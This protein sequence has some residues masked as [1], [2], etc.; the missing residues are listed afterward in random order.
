MIHSQLIV[1][2]AIAKSIVIAI[3]FYGV[4]GIAIAIAKMGPQPI[5]E[6]N[7]N[8]NRVINFRCEWT[9]TEVNKSHRLY[10]YSAFISREAGD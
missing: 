9:L 8:G 4:I 3:L 1:Y 2:Y 10:I 5:L 7:G 6:P